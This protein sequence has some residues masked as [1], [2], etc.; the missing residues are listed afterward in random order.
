MSTP[1]TAFV[2]ENL[3]PFNEHLDDIVEHDDPAGTCPALSRTLLNRWITDYAKVTLARR[4]TN[5]RLREAASISQ[6]QWERTTELLPPGLDIN[7]QIS[8]IRTAVR[9][10]RMV[11]ESIPEYETTGKNASEMFEKL[12][13]T[14]TSVLPPTTTTAPPP[15]SPPTRIRQTDMPTFDGDSSKFREWEKRTRLVLETYVDTT[16]PRNAL[17]AILASLTGAAL[18]WAE[19]VTPSQFF[20]PGMTTEHAIDYFFEDIKESFEDPDEMKNAR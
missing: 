5:Q 15:P 19:E 14:L 18:T 16:S 4:Q 6:Q 9:I 17:A 12:K 20:R 8:A 11:H 13:K 10:L 1:I 2:K 7:G 3:L